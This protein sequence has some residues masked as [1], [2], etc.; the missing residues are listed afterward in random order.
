RII[1]PIFQTALDFFD[2]AARAALAQDRRR[3]NG[4]F[5]DR[6][7]LR[8]N[9]RGRSRRYA[10]DERER[11]RA[12]HQTFFHTV[13]LCLR[14]AIWRK[15]CKKRASPPEAFSRKINFFTIFR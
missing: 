15:I 12:D 9:E 13:L 10:S 14:C 3:R 5:R 6:G 7:L 2:L 4:K 8:G 1:P 11:H